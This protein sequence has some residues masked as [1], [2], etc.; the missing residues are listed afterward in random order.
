M[1]RTSS[2]RRVR[3]EKLLRRH[4]RDRAGIK[5]LGVSREKDL[6]FTGQGGCELEGVFEI[7]HVIRDGV[8]GIGFRCFGDFGPL[9]KADDR[10]H[11]ER[12]GL[13]PAAN[14]VVDV[15]EA[16]PCDP[17]FMD[18]LGTKQGAAPAAL[19]SWFVESEVQQD[20]GVE[21]ET[22]LLASK[23]FIRGD[24][25]HM[26][27]VKV[28]VA[29]IGLGFFVAGHRHGGSHR[30]HVFQSSLFAVAHYGGFVGCLLFNRHMQFARF[31]KAV[32]R[33]AVPQ[34]EIGHACDRKLKRDRAHNVSILTSCLKGRNP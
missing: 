33:R 14:D 1:I 19:T 11:R 27:L 30:V 6:G 15:R 31:E 21:K 2:L 29:G 4:H 9:E 3:R 16:V 12:F 24:A 18:S 34:R 22:H 28:V 25:E 7:R 23:D 17:A 20:I 26:L 5:M 10:A 32:K 8:I 13:G